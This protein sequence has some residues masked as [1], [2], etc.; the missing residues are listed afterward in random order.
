MALAG[1][2]ST[3]IQGFCDKNYKKGMSF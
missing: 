3:F 2:G 1:S